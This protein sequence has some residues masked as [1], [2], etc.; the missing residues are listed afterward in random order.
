M[1]GYE[2]WRR[3]SNLICPIIYTRTILKAQQ[4]VND[5]IKNPVG[6]YQSEFRMRHKD[7]H[8]VIQ[9]VVNF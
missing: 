7:G 2:A 5:Y 1:I 4:V 6:N 3:R 8:W 9:A